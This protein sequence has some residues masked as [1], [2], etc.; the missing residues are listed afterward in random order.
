MEHFFIVL[1]VL[2][3][4]IMWSCNYKNIYFNNE[5]LQLIKFGVEN[6][7]LYEIHTITIF[8]EYVELIENCIN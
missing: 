3:M 2:I 7:E 4:S 6:N 1:F 8:Y 5:L